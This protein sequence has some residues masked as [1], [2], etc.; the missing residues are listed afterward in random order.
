MLPRPTG[1]RAY[2]QAFAVDDQHHSGRMKKLQAKSARP[3]AWPRVKS[4]RA[5]PR[6]VAGT[7]HVETD[8]EIAARRG[9]GGRERC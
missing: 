4:R 6:A 8:V 3:S 5:V 1:H 7:R 9:R 2:G